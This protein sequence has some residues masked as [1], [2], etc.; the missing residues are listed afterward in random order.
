[1]TEA[2][3]L[4]EA[5]GRIADALQR[6]KRGFC[7]VGGLA[8]SVRGEVRFTRDVDLAVAVRDDSD[9][10]MLV[11]DLQSEGYRPIAVVEHETT[12]RL[13]TARLMSPSGVKVDLL[14]ASCGIEPDIVSRA[15]SV[16][17]P[18]TGAIPV[19]T[20]EDLLAMKTLS[21]TEHR[22]QDRLDARGLMRVATALDLEQVRRALRSIT[23]RGY[24]RQRD[25]D[26]QLS[27]VVEEVSR[28]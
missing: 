2:R 1:M 24:N 8:V 25:L 15:T 16:E 18:V 10:E 7:L 17:L 3:P 11:R 5:L 4:E 21:M 26:A 28:R 12:G 13:S 20:A 14:F 9:A 19:A 6:R 27:S 22:L 23:E